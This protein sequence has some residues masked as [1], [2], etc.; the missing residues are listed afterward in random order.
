MRWLDSVKFQE[1]KPQ[2]LLAIIRVDEVYKK[3]GY[4]FWITSANDSQHKTNS[5]H[6]TGYAF[7]CRTKNVPAQ[8][9][10]S[11]HAAIQACL[12]PQFDCVL[13]SDH[14]HVEYD[15]KV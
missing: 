13:E 7:D 2:T 9:H 11:L 8:L 15:P 6:Y 1:L 14:I 4:E 3:F 10:V 5:L 12:G